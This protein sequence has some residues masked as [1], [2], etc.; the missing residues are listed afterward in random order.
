MPHSRTSRVPSPAR[1][2]SWL[3]AVLTVLAAC[4]AS[5]EAA[6]TP[7]PWTFTDPKD[8]PFNPLRY[9]SNNT[10]SAIAISLVLATALAQTILLWRYGG[11]CM[12]SMLIGEFT[13]AVGFGVRFGL[14]VDPDSEGKY[15]AYY[16]FIVLSPC[17]FIASEYMLMG[18]L[19]RY[20]KSN[21]HLLIRPQR[22]TVVFVI[23]DVTTF[24]VQAAGALLSIS[25][26][27]KLSKTGEHIFLAGLALQLASFAFFV[28]VALR[29]LYRVKTMEPHTWAMDREKPWHRDW[30]ALSYVL[31]ISSVGILIRCVYRVIELSQGYRGHLATTEGY[32]YGL[33]SLPLFIA[34]VVYTPFWPGRM[35]PFIDKLANV[36]HIDTPP[37]AE[38]RPSSGSEEAKT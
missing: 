11:R 32:F 16:L 20:I 17:A 10:L 34:V 35:I 22:I 12:L 2:T 33:D 1:T 5:A 36:D 13:W 8:D 6:Y 27:Q 4:A 30:R 24:L 9:I 7:V 19:A 3:C 31:L 14:H 38:E 21:K 28:L 18:R 37:V 25:H 29:F 23:S 15:I 26:N